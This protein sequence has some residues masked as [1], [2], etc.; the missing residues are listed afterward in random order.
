[1]IVERL[2]TIIIRMLKDVKRML[3]DG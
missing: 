3:N 1:M 2:R